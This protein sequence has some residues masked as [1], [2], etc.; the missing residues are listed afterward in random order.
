[1]QTLKTILF[2]ASIISLLGELN[3]KYPH[4]VVIY[5]NATNS[6][7]GGH[8]DVYQ[9]LAKLNSHWISRNFDNN[10]SITKEINFLHLF[11]VNKISDSIHLISSH[12]LKNSNTFRIQNVILS[13]D[14]ESND[15]KAEI[16]GIHKRF[17]WNTLICERDG[18]RIICWYWKILNGRTTL[19]DLLD[20]PINLNSLEIQISARN[21]P[22]MAFTPCCSRRFMFTGLD[23]M[24]SAEILSTFNATPRY[25]NKGVVAQIKRT[26]CN[27]VDKIEEGDATELIQ[28]L[29]YSKK[30]AE[31]HAYYHTVFDSRMVK[32]LFYGRA[33]W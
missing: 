13:N 21:S 4:P 9:T 29:K 27:R 2:N 22:P 30:V 31:D 6:I 10:Q 3:R 16:F 1:M 28:R 26:E 32:Y 5:E 18:E 33:E 23:A 25:C 17:Q 7:R 11:C 24:V 8:L 20:A 19:K 12:I 15:L 14:H